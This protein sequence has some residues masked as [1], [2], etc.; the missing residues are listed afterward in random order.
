MEELAKR[1]DITDA[2]KGG[3][4]VIMNVEKYIKNTNCQ[5]S[6]KRNNKTLQ[7][8]PALQR[9]TLVNDTMNRLKKEN[10]LSKKLDD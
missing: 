2:D 6:E 1:M 9:S 10:Q 5:L 4:V 3:A 7:E 8:D